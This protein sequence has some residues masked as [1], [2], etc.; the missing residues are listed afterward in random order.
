M[1]VNYMAL[2]AAASQ[3]TTARTPAASTAAPAAQP[4]RRRPNFLEVV[5]RIGDTLALMGG[6]EPLF[7]RFQA[8][9][10]A[11]AK[12]ARDAEE[13]AMQRNVL[14]QFLSNNPQTQQFAPLLQ[15]GMGVEDI[16]RIAGLTQGPRESQ[17][18]ASIQEIEYLNNPN[19]PLEKRQALAA[20]INNRGLSGAMVGTPDTGWRTNPMFRPLPVPG[21]TQPAPQQAPAAQPQQAA[22]NVVTMQDLQRMARG[23]GSADAMMNWMRRNSV[24]VRV[25]TPQEAMNLPSGTPIL[26][27]DGTIG[28]VP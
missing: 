16:S 19:I 10:R 17:G 2:P 28:S 3:M 1:A 13:M 26:L 15:A 25:A 5:G 9:E 20:V 6:R 27:P 11:A 21:A 4:Q 14:A 24:T 23:M 18:P 12:Q 22:S 7:E 8:Q